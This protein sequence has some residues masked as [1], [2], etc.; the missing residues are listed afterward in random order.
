MQPAAGATY[1][2]EPVCIPVDL[3]ELVDVPANHPL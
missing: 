3:D 2:F 1:K